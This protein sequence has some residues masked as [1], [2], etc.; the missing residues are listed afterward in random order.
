MDKSTNDDMQQ[1]SLAAASIETVQLLDGLSSLFHDTECIQRTNLTGGTIE[2]QL[3]RFRIW[4]GNLG[5]LHGLPATS[6]LDYRLRELPRVAHQ[7]H[8]LLSDLRD[9][10]RE[11]NV[12]LHW[13]VI[14]G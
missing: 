12:Q 3:S 9:I 13:C 7:I 8:D 14:L 11:G 5:A 10:T 1:R 4:C 6:S 2:D